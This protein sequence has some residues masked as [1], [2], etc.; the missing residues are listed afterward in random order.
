MFHQKI[1]LVSSDLGRWRGSISLGISSG[2]SC[3]CCFFFVVESLVL[4]W[5]LSDGGVGDVRDGV[6]ELDS[7]F[8]AWLGVYAVDVRLYCFCC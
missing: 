1:P 7:K 8:D 4:L 6:D 5:F 2:Y 3:F